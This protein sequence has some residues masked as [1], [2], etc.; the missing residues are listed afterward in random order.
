MADDE[1][2]FIIDYPYTDELVERFARLQMLEARRR[3][4]LAVGV[5]LLVFGCGLAAVPPDPAQRWIGV[6]LAAL[7]IFAFWCRANLDRIMTGRAR[8][9]LAAAGDGASRRRPIVVADDGMAVEMGGTDSR[10]FPFADMTDVISGDGVFIAVF[11]AEGVLVPRDAF[12]MGSP[13]DFA[14]FIEG[15]R[16]PWR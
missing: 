11:G 5:P 6:L 2:R 13:D 10:F 15:R 7:G 8:G 12:K 1:V 9:S 14:A 4:L 3:M 16:P